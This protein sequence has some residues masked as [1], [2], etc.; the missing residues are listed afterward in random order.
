MPHGSPDGPRPSSPFTSA[1]S[2]AR[3]LRIGALLG[4]AFGSL[5]LVAGS[6]ASVSNGEVGQ[7]PETVAP[8]A[9]TLPLTAFADVELFSDGEL[10]LLGAG[11]VWMEEASQPTPT[12]TH[13]PPT[14]TATATVVPAIPT[15]TTVPP[16]PRSMQASPTLPPSPP[17]PPPPPATAT[18]AP[19]PPPPAPSSL[20]TSAMDAYSRALLEGTNARRVANGLA[21]L[22]EDG[23]LNGIARIRSQDMA[24]HDYFAHVSPITGDDA[25]SLMDKHGVP[26]GWAGENLAKNNYPAGETVAV[27]EQALWD[28]PPHRENI[29][30]PHYTHVGIALVVDATGMKYFTVVFTGAG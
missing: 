30:N 21:P 22:I 8:G 19:P 17:A 6:V 29:L 20:D 5:V 10:T 2:L 14:A 4:G 26:F 15:P 3:A 28:S 16:T 25:F 13:A 24:D 12:P 27:A 18:P 1:R 11:I 7:A 9:P 23:N